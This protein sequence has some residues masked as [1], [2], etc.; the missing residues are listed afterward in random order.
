[1]FPP[2][3]ADTQEIVPSVAAPLDAGAHRH[4]KH[5]VI[6]IQENRSFESFFAGYPGADAP[7]YGCGAPKTSTLSGED[8][9]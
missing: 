5:I 6:I 4:I 2:H 8:E 7:M 3:S 1:M 9:A